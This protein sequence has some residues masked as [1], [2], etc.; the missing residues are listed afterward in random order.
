MTNLMQVLKY[1]LALLVLSFFIGSSSALFL[2]ILDLVTD[3]RTENVS[4]I[5]LLPL[6]GAFIAWTYHK[7]GSEVDA[8]NVVFKDAFSGKRKN[9]PFRMYPLVLIGTWLTHLFGGS[10]G[11]EGTTLQMGAAVASQWSKL[12]SWWKSHQDILMVI[13]VSGGF[14]SVFGTPLAGAVFALEYLRRKD[15]HHP[16]LIITAFISAFLSNAACNIWGIH[17]ST[18]DVQPFDSIHPNT[19]F[20]LLLIGSAG[21]I[22]GWLY[23]KMG[24]VFKETFTHFFKNKMLRA[25]VGGLFIIAVVL[26]L[27]TD[28]HI[29]LGVPYIQLSFLQSSP[30]Q[31]WLIKLLLTAFTLAAGFRGG[32]VTPLF[33]IGATMASAFGFYYPDELSILAAAGFVSVF[34]YVTKTPIACFLMAIELFG[35]SHG[36]T[37]GISLFVVSLITWKR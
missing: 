11:R 7:Y 2:Y 3:L 13:G 1:G 36:L 22:A 30:P 25:F 9:V 12:D 27:N 5:L 19:I 8:G 15:V 37:S 28:R 10:A 4:I 6:A 16:V 24:S 31:D 20:H 32:E 29:G 17:H 26:L 23:L 21:S 34:A 14:A 18:Y 35:V 33:Y